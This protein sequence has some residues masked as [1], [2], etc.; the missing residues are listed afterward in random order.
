MLT[1]RQYDEADKAMWDDF[2]IRRSRNATFLFCRD[3]VEYHA[4]RF[5][6]NSLIFS[7]GNRP[8]ALFLASRHGDVL[9]AHG[10]LTYGG[11]VM[12]DKGFGAAAAI[13]VVGAL[14]DYCRAENISRIIYKPVPHIYHRY[15]SEEDTY[16]IVASGGRLCEAAV[17]ST[18]D[19]TA[20]LRPDENTRRGLRRAAA[21]GI[22]VR[23]TDDYAGFWSL[24]TNNLAER[25][26]VMPVHTVG[27][28]MLLASRFPDNIRLYAA[29]SPEGGM[30]AGTVVYL[31]D[32]VAHTQY[33]S[34]SPRGRE[35][36]ALVPVMFKVMDDNAGIRRYLDFGISTEDHGRVLNTGLVRQKEGYGARS[37][38]YTAY[39]IEI[40]G[41]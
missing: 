18:I 38:V 21:A 19:L 35:L 3:Y 6:D 14:K 33:I 10:G 2:V 25:H 29:Y 15:P 32:T 13:A 17:S 36:S 40:V 26:N 7:D 8:V 22:Y 39:S 31:T 30:L 20:P 9:R 34:S 24:L 5:T 41:K 4:D 12:P 16:A 11:L 23:Q 28:I 1:L 27:E 37:T